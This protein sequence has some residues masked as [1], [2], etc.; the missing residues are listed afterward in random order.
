MSF[1]TKPLV[2]VIVPLFNHER[3]VVDCLQSIVNNNYRPL[4]IIVL[5]DGSSDSSYQKACDWASKVHELGL[6]ISIKRQENQGLNKTLNNLVKMAQGEFIA[7]IASDDCLTPN[8]IEVRVN[9]LRRHPEWLVVFGDAHVIDES[10]RLLFNSFLY[11]SVGI[12]KVALKNPKFITLELILRWSTPGGSFL[13][14]KKVYDPQQ[15]VGLYD[16]T[17]PFEDRDFYLRSLAINVVGFIDEY[18]SLYRWHSTN[19]VK[20]MDNQFKAKLQLG[21]Y[22]SEKKNIKLFRGINKL[23]LMLSAYRCFCLGNYYASSKLNYLIGAKVANRLIKIIYYLHT[24]RQK[25][26]S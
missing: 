21:A 15:G 20:N 25:F 19:S 16:E 12:N 13:A 1:E 5:D 17:L 24:L 11:E 18:V 9:A 6:S 14:R 3:F 23:A 8:S 4:E 26:S 2:S 10:N 22:L 7:L